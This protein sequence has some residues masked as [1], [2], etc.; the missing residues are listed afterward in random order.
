MSNLGFSLDRNFNASEAIRRRSRGLS[1]VAADASPQLG[2]WNPAS[3]A[4]LALAFALLGALA[5]KFLF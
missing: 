3:V 2:R 1:P 5:A 4:G